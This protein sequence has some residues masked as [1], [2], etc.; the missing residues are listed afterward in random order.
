MRIAV[1]LAELKT[2]RTECSEYALKI[3]SEVQFVETPKTLGKIAHIVREEKLAQLVA[4]KLARDKQ[5]YADKFA[6][7]VA[8]K[9]EL[10]EQLE[11][12]R[13]EQRRL[14]EEDRLLDE[15]IKL[16]RE[17]VDRRDAK[18]KHRL[19]VK[20]AQLLSDE[21]TEDFNSQDE[22]NANEIIQTDNQN[23]MLTLAQTNVTKPLPSEKRPAPTEETTNNNHTSGGDSAFTATNNTGNTSSALKSV[24]QL[25]PTRKTRR[26]EPV[27]LTK[28]AIKAKVLLEEYG[29]DPRC[30]V[31]PVE[32]VV[33]RAAP[34]YQPVDY[35]PKEWNIPQAEAY[36]KHFSFETLDTGIPHPEK[37]TENDWTQLCRP[38]SNEIFN[39][40]LS[41]FVQ[42]SLL[43]PVRAQCQMVNR[44]LMALL[45]GNEH[46]L[47]RHLDTLRQF[48]F[49]DN[50]PFSYSL[51]RS[52]GERLGQLT[53]AHQLVN[54]P[55]MNFILQTALN[56]VHADEHYAS[57]LSFYI[58]ET[59][60]QHAKSHFDVLDCFT[61]RYRVEWPL[62]LILTEEIMDSYSQIFSFILQVRLAAWS[63]QD[64]FASMMKLDPD[65][66]IPV[67][68]ARHGIE[69]FV[70]TMQNYVMSQ[71]LNLA[72]NDF[73]NELKKSARSLDDL[74][75]IHANYVHRA[76]ARLL[77]TAKSASLMKIIR[78][79]LGLSLKFRSLLLAADFQHTPQL[80]V[81][82]KSI[83][84]KAKEYAKF[85]RLSKCS[86]LYSCCTWNH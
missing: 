50:G 9:A 37:N 63:M 44:S 64:V 3:P 80:Q 2:I 65:N 68:G 34:R 16:Y 46:R 41:F 78:D 54:V 76:K 79:A 25:K 11:L 81:Q 33:G 85:I 27:F 8:A 36:T 49:L 18:E 5:K 53:H 77:L 55:S 71:L 52:I 45:I 19:L 4:E 69:F 23:N 72:W 20:Y 10:D 66:W 67:H 82:V 75:N 83:H 22:F 42:R 47:M 21:P 38:E 6:R 86:L 13:A 32:I 73:V 15:D 59:P 31:Q 17:L 56:A 48:L 30:D 60:G 28:E 12:K 57:R 74:Y 61:L 35:T 70:H 39:L 51:A 29:I 40:S 62:N 43:L 84:N 24:T 14:A 26:K 1:S 58:K 7:N